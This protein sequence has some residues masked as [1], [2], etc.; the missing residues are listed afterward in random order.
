[1]TSILFKRGNTQSND[2]Y[3]G[4]LGEITLDTQLR[5]LRIHDGIIPGGTVVANLNDLQN[6]LDDLGLGISDIEGLES[7]LSTINVSIN[8]LTGRVETLETES[9]KRDGSVAFT[10]NVN[11]GNNRITN[12][13]TPTQSTDA[14]SKQYV[15]D[16][17]NSLGNVFTYV[18]S[19]DA[20]TENDPF[21]LNG[22]ELTSAG[23][24]YTVDSEGFV[25]DG[26]VVSHVN[27]T[28]GI[29]FKTDGYKVIDNTNAQ[30]SG[31]PGFVSVGGSSETG[32][33]VDIDQNFK[34]RVTALEEAPATPTNVTGS[35]AIQV[36]NTDPLNPVVSISE[37]TTTNPGSMSASDKQKLDSIAE[38]A[39]VNTVDS[40][41]GKTGTVVLVKGDVGLSNV[42]NYNTA[43]E[44]QSI[45]GNANN[46]YITPGGVR[47]FIEDGEYV[48][49]AGTF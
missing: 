35:G 26:N 20:G 11:A 29:L 45:A 12:V 41:A 8:A 23:S 27:A 4:Q 14:A 34:N 44:A 33:T 18:G 17:I 13:S 21:D 31:S 40:V 39:Q 28:D 3:T 48:I 37:A 16:E 2:S 46:L 36:D 15:D 38:G 7:A 22:L 5:Q 25:T 30:V 19:L 32:Y 9:I 6:A 47:S 1:M 24:Y 10:G 42:Q 49:D 43:N